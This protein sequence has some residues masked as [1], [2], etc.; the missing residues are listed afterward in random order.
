LRETD[1]GKEFKSIGNV[2]LLNKLMF[3][4]VYIVLFGT[5]YVCTYLSCIKCIKFL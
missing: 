4:Q 1:W 2:N 3:I 5:Y